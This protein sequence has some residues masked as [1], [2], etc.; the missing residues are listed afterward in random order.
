[1]SI[2]FNNIYTPYKVD[3][4]PLVD[5]STWA[6]RTY[7]STYRN[8]TELDQTGIDYLNSVRGTN[9]KGVFYYCS[10]LIS[11]DLSNFDTS[12]ATDMNG[13][14]YVCR[15]LISLDLSNFDT[16][17][18]TDMGNMFSVCN[19]LIS[20]DLSN[21]DTSNVTNMSAMFYNCSLLEYLIIGSS[22]FKFQ[23]KESNCGRLNTTC[24]ILVP[25][26]LLDTYKTATNW[27][28]IASQ[29]D[30]IENY[31]ITRSNGQV[32]VTPK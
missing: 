7:P 12:N 13:M 1:M 3:N 9:M 11:L 8:M 20:L 23:M 10:S 2:L 31:T 22:T 27:S 32:T 28:S 29:F 25:S 24:K 15:S 30:A 19:S 17:N 4:R 6:I 18:V 16:S 21:F 5:L 14:F 26:S